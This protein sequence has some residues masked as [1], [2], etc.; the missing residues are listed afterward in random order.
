MKP[1]LGLLALGLGNRVCSSDRSHRP[2]ALGQCAVDSAVSLEQAFLDLLAGLT[3]G[4]LDPGRL[5][6]SAD[7]LVPRFLQKKKMSNY[8]CVR[9]T[10]VWGRMPLGGGWCLGSCE[11]PSVGAE[12][13]SLVLCKNSESP[14]LLSHLSS[15]G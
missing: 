6:L 8:V 5:R 7:F 13:R 11:L 10:Y 1:C 14:Y 2:T 3:S 12:N 9:M 4:L 15:P